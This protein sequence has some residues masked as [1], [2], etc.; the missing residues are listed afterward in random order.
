MCICVCCKT[1]WKRSPLSI[2]NVNM[3]FFSLFFY[4]AS[5]KRKESLKRSEEWNVKKCAKDVAKEKEIHS[6]SLLTS[7]FKSPKLIVISTKHDHFVI[8]FR[9]CHCRCCRFWCCSGKYRNTFV[10]R[11]MNGHFFVCIFSKWNL[12]WKLI[13]MTLQKK[14]A[15][16]WSSL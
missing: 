8:I 10:I 1:A 2:V 3:F 4:R 11:W 15:Q 9:C 5:T 14:C 12:R 6:S 13:A 16:I 7:K